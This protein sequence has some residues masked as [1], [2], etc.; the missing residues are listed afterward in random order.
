M[1]TPYLSDLQYLATVQL[2]YCKKYK[3]NKILCI[4]FSLLYVVYTILMIWTLK[5]F[6]YTSNILSHMIL[7]TLYSVSTAAVW[8]YCA[9]L[10]STFNKL[11]TIIWTSDLYA[12]IVQHTY[13]IICH[14]K[15]VR[16]LQF[17]YVSYEL[18]LEKKSCQT[19]KKKKNK[20]IFGVLR[21]KVVLK[22]SVRLQKKK[23]KKS[24]SFKNILCKCDS[25][26]Y[27]KLSLL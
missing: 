25:I 4:T 1:F 18:F 14:S 26:N 3:H 13:M 6:K 5:V 20:V 12:S 2:N 24:A 15:P 22:F 19:P 9:I 16:P 10:V 17:N 27:R 23:E 21:T 11:R 8:F 7:Y